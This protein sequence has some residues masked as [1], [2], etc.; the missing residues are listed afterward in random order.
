MSGDPF[1]KDS[2]LEDKEQGLVE[3]QGGSSTDSFSFFIPSP[4]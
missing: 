1:A 4:E 2:R 3:E